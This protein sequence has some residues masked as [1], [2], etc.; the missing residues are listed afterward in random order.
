MEVLSPA[1][2]M[3]N[4]K[5]C[6][7]CGADAVYLGLKKFSARSNAGNFN[8]D[9][10]AYA[11]NYTHLFGVKVYITVNTL[12]K[13]AEIEEF[14]N[15][16]GYA[17]NLGADAFIL[18]D[19]YLG[20]LLKKYFPS[21]VLHLST[22]GGV[23]N[24]YGAKNA[25]KYGFSRVILSRETK[26]ADVKKICKITETEVFVHG[27]LCTSFSGH[28][29][30]SSFIGGLSGNR[31]ECKQPCRK[32]YS[33]LE[34]GCVD[35]KG[36]LISLS[37]LCLD[38]QI[39]TLKDIGVSSIKIEGRMRGIEYVS[40]ATQYYKNLVNG[41]FRQDLFKAIRKTFN[42]GDFTEG[43]TFDSTNIISDKIQSHK[44]YKV[45]IIA[46]IFDNKLFFK[47]YY[48]FKNGDAFKI[49]R[50][51][52]EVGNAI[53]KDV[54][55]KLSV[56]YNGNAKIGD[57]LNITKDVSISEKYVLK[58][59]YKDI[60]VKVIAKTGELLSLSACGITV[61]S[62]NP[63][64]RAETA[65]ATEESIKQNLLKTDIYPFNV[66]DAEIEI[67][68]SPFIVKGVLN[69]LRAKLYKS[70][71]YGKKNIEYNTVSYIEDEIENIKENAIKC[72]IISNITIIDLLAKSGYTDVAYMPN[73]YSKLDDL[74][75]IS[76]V[77]GF[78]LWLYLPPNLTG[79]ELTCI[80]NYVNNFYG[81]Y[82]ECYWAEE[83]ADTFN[84]K[85]MR[86]AG[87]NVFN[88]IDVAASLIRSERFVYS[89]EL[90]V[91]EINEIK[92][93]GIIINDGAIELMD[94]SYC[95]FK[96]E[97][98][99]CKRGDNFILK[100]EFSHEFPVIKY[101]TNTAKGECK[102]KVFNFAN[103]H[104]DKSLF[105]GVENFSVINDFRPFSNEKIKNI[106]KSANVDE[107]KNALNHVT[108]GNYIKGVK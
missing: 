62:E 97:C 49:I 8:D 87:F 35:R 27:A 99:I 19:V 2:N 42:R 69:K 23:I 45:G 86:G 33:L 61:Y 34:N 52:R 29:Y 4:L 43:L 104:I 22:Q 65:P 73:D 71:F 26:L 75:S 30:F 55:G 74:S 47:D 103:V 11:I 31:G 12:I 39:E 59:K 94:L 68:G 53:A 9:E 44:G 80:S 84:L 82:G 5:A 46:K 101:K 64:L 66:V 32:A 51:G 83:F 40:V 17:L 54:N 10:L 92:S 21:I 70:I 6:V 95:I 50:D 41:I 58:E 107:L 96:R 98:S 28:C 56:Y 85:L 79:D 14:I 67:S 25:K 37:D 76:K 78:R 100:D 72:A 88:K 90:C 15:S 38:K 89:K 36:Y 106:I 48:N 18:Q 24:E 93:S 13:D 81:V 57:D 102:F 63:L 60:K 77:S 1:G 105:S 3:E 91:N 16:V 108:R 7:A 20:G